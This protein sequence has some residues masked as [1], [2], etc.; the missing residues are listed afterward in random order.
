MICAIASVYLVFN[1]FS[2]LSPDGL[3]TQVLCRLGA[4]KTEGST[5]SASTIDQLVVKRDKIAIARYSQRPLLM[6]AINNL[7]SD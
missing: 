1:T 3:N 2:G 7:E 6:D 4:P 5:D